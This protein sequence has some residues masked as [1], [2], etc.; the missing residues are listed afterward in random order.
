MENNNLTG[1][2]VTSKLDCEATL[3]GAGQF[4]LGASGLTIIGSGGAAGEKVEKGRFCMDNE[5]VRVCKDT[6]SDR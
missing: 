4:R 3:L 2:L 1:S 5:R 6:V